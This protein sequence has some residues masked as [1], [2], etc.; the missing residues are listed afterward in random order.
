M[1][2]APA[3]FAWP[4]LVAVAALFLYFTLIANVGR[5]RAKYK[6]MPPQMSGPPEFERVLRVQANTLEQL[7]I[8]LPAL[9]LFAFALSP[10]WGAGV[11]AVWVVGRLLYAWGYY[12]AAE[13]RMLGFA[14]AAFSSLTLLLGA[15]VGLVLLLV[16]VSAAP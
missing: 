5:A 4:G 15:L 1:A 14:L 8:F 9:G 10:R 16:P 11:G 6:V 3:E 12:Q 7:I 2:S 13:K